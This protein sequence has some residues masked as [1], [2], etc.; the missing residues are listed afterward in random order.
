MSA[1]ENKWIV[2]I[3]LKALKMGMTEGSVLQCLH[4]DANDVYNVSSD[5]VKICT[6]LTDPNVRSTEKS[7]KLF[8]SFLPMLAGRGHVED[9]MKNMDNEPFDVELKLD[10]ER[11]LLHRVRIHPY[12]I[13]PHQLPS[14]CR[15]EK[16]TFTARATTTT[17]PS[18]MAAVLARMDA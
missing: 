12:A 9:T 14:C 11:I 6:E 8:S 17:T 15:T 10:G 18:C 2:K 5:I 3:I 13:S 4:P 16:G 7:I 1:L